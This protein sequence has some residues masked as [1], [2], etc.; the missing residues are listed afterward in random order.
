MDMDHLDTTTNT[1]QHA[2]QENVEES[3]GQLK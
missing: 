2:I 3:V 1:Y